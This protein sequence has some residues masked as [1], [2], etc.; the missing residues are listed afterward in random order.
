MPLTDLKVGRAAGRETERRPM[1]APDKKDQIMRSLLTAALAAAAFLA[2]AA[3]DS[4]AIIRLAQ[5]NAEEDACMAQC[6]RDF[7][8]CDF[9]VT[10]MEY[11]CVEAGAAACEADD[12]IPTDQI[13]ACM[14]ASEAQ[15]HSK[16]AEGHAACE[17]G[18]GEQCYM[19][20]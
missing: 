10:S 5:G 9:A 20:C 2:A 18:F 17:S 8:Q 13:G 12:S 3:A 19:R 1:G 11:D 4:G 7:A 16:Y 6:D 14:Q 15:C